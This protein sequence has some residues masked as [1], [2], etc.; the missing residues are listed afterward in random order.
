[1]KT[2]QILALACLCLAGCSTTKPEAEDP[3]LKAKMDAVIKMNADRS[4]ARFLEPYYEDA[5]VQS[6]QRP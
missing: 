4:Q 5:W 2:A 6:R 3:A 1:M